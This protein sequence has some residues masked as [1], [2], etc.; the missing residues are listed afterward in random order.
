MLL[1]VIIPTWNVAADL[2]ATVAALRNE[3]AR[4]ATLKGLQAPELEIVVA[5]GGS[6]DGTLEVASAL[7]ARVVSAAKTRGALLRAGAS[8][9]RGEWLLFL[10]ADTRLGEAWAVRVAG[11]IANPRHFGQ[12]AVFRFRFDDDRPWARRLEMLVDRCG[13][14]LALPSRDQGLLIGR[15]FYD[16]LGGY[17]DVAPVEDVE[18]LDR[19]GRERLCFLPVA[20]ITPWARYAREGYLPRM[21]RSFFCIALWFVGIPA[22]RIARITAKLDPAE[23]RTEAVSASG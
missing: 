10:H 19:I 1:S 5:D 3:I 11:F 14:W 6:T 4:T 2:P 15:E 21:L 20:A 7:G 17:P 18:M 9:A 8:A 12:A 23:A 13:R 22:E 16:A